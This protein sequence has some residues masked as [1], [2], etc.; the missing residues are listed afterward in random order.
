MMAGG[1]LRAMARRAVS[2]DDPGLPPDAALVAIL[3]VL[4][5]AGAWVAWGSRA[6][7]PDYDAV[8]YVHEAW[9]LHRGMAAGA[10]PS[11]LPFTN[12]LDVLVV[13]AL[14]DRMDFHLA[15][16]AMQSIY[17]VA[18]AAGVRRLLGPAAAVFL[19]GWCAA[20][21]YFLHQ[22]TSFISEMKVGLWLVL[23]AAA[24]F[25]PEASRHPRLLFV[26]A[27]VLLLL[28]ALDLAFIVALCAAFAAIRWRD[29]WL[30]RDIVRVLAAPAAAVALLAPLI[31]PEILRLAAYVRDATGRT[32]RNWADMSAI[33]DKADL[34]AAYVRGLGEYNVAFQV[35]AL[36]ALLVVARRVFAGRGATLAALRDPLLATACVCATL[37]LAATTNIQVVFWP[38]ALE[39]L[40]AMVLARTL[41]SR[42]AFVALACGLA[43]WGGAQT[44]R[45]VLAWDEAMR[46]DAPAQAL[47]RQMAAILAPMPHAVFFENFGGYGPADPA[48][49]EIAVDRPLAWTG[50]PLSYSLDTAAYLAAFDHA[51]VAFI[52]NRPFLWPRYWGINRHTAQLHDVIAERA[53]VQGWQHV[54]RLALGDDRSRFVDVYVR[55]G[56]RAGR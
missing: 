54:D 1:R 34:V 9:R 5:P 44:A 55:Q 20:Q 43:L 31:A 27:L 52:A 32:G 13:A 37:L 10:L 42:G 36:L 47:A 48:G 56:T 19:V 23:F 51:N 45:N 30:T 50:D 14:W 26:S 18:F 33:H 16:W 15:V 12:T 21:G 17:L 24:L 22:Y 4:V 11:A 35:A 29:G 7:M 38:F 41:L 28:R 8:S 40:L 2:S 46:R 3:A 6:T 53:P 39:G 25:S 49:L